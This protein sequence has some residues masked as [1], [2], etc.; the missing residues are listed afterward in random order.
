MLVMRALL[1]L[2]ALMAL[3]HA[4]A[5]FMNYGLAGSKEL[6]SAYWF[7][8][9]IIYL[10]CACVLVLAGGWDRPTL[11]LAAISVV[12]LVSGYRHQAATFAQGMAQDCAWTQTH[13]AKLG[14]FYECAAHDRSEGSGSTGINDAARCAPSLQ[15]SCDYARKHCRPT[16]YEDCTA[17]MDRCVTVPA[18]VCESHRS[19][20]LV[21]PNTN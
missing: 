2:N 7:G 8:S 17:G 20:Q 14:E 6:V 21:C 1:A 4:Y 9:S 12:I 19:Y 10:F 11:I 16:R 13:C 5:V 18:Y 3:V 15:Q